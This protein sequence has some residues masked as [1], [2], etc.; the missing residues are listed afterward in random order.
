LFPSSSISFLRGFSGV[1]FFQA[2]D[3]TSTLFDISKWIIGFSVLQDA[4]LAMFH[5]KPI[6]N[7]VRP[8]SAIRYLYANENIT[9]YAGPY[10][11]TKTYPC[12]HFNSYLRAVPHADWPSG[13]ACICV[14]YAEW[15]E[16][17]LA[18]TGKPFLY[19]TFIPKGCSMK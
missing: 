15:W 14:A 18:S 17:Y 10:E 13:T 16:K 9:A 5:I 1:P 4:S 19:T 7:A 12:R 11:G 2:L 3:P 6:I 8:V